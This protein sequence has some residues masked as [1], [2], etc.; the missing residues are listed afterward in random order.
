MSKSQYSED[1]KARLIIAVLDDLFP[2][3]P[4]PLKHKDPFTLLISVLLSAQTTDVMVNRVT[5]ALFEK[6]DTAKSMSRLSAGQIQEIIRPVGLAPGK[7]KAIHELSNLLI[8][9]HDGEVPANF[10]DYTYS[11]PRLSLGPLEREIR[12]A[13][14]TR[15]EENF[16]EKSLDKAT[17]A[18]HLLW[19]SVLSGS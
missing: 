1:K 3:P 6:A 10:E 2:Q 11:P 7:A 17:F 14:R 18:N 15:L 16:S 19:T 12:R 8:M 4:I 13:D 9:K 5:P